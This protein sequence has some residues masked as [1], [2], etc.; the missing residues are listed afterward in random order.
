MQT[1]RPTVVASAWTLVEILIVLTVLAIAAAIVVPSMG[2]AG[3]SQATSAA[4][5]LESDLEVARSLALTT[6]QPHSLVFSTDRQSYKVV[7]NYTGGA[8]DSATAVLNPVVP[9]KRLQVTFAKENGMSA[10]VVGTVTFGGVTY[11]TFN[12][13]GEPSA[14]G[15]VMLSA[16]R[17]TMR[18]LVQSLTGTVTVTRVAG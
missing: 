7:A 16:G 13:Y 18:V 10:V 11:V 15:G 12:S 14:T 5:V 8:Y 2:T 6:Q 1:A 17:T 4:Q 3:D 9:G